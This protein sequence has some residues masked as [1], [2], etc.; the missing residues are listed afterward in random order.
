VKDCWTIS[1]CSK[2][3]Y[4]EKTVCQARNHHLEKDDHAM[5]S[6]CMNVANSD[7]Q[8]WCDAT[9]CR[10]KISGLYFREFVKQ[11]FNINLLTRMSDCCICNDDDF[12]LCLQ[13]AMGGRVCQD[14]DHNL[15]PSVMTIIK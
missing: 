15:S 3:F 8:I 5:H 14:M 6:T 13:C 1:H 11:F 12:H 7:L 4:G 9:D 10:K 2:C